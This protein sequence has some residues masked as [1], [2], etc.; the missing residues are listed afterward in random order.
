TVQT[1][2]T[3][4]PRPYFREPQLL[5]TMNPVEWHDI[6]FAANAEY[7][8]FRQPACLNA[9]RAGVYPTAT[10][11]TRGNAWFV[12]A[13]AGL[14]LTHYDFLDDSALEEKHLNRSVPITSL[15]GGLVFERD[16]NM[17]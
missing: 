17:F 12:T 13:R 5:A 14:H 8:R 10:W 2:R 9:D 11:P 7:V 6:D 1:T 15:D 4:P 16:T 3:P